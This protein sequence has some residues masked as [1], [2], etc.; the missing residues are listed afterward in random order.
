MHSDHMNDSN[1]NGGEPTRFDGSQQPSPLDDN[2]R[3]IVDALVRTSILPSVEGV[4][5]TRLAQAIGEA[6]RKRAI[7]TGERGPD[8]QEKLTIPSIQDGYAMI[9]SIAHKM[10]PELDKVELVRSVLLSSIKED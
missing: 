10:H 6:I 2:Q 5:V 8:G 9:A 1:M 7:L 3:A 4:T